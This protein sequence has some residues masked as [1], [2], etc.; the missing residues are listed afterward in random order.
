MERKF[1]LEKWRNGQI[2]FHRTKVHSRLAQFFDQFNLKEREKV[3]LPLC[4]KTLDIAWLLERE[5]HVVGVELSLIAVEQLFE[6]LRIEPEVTVQ[7]NFQV[8]RS[9]SLTIYHGDFFNLTSNEL[10]GVKGIYDRA[11]M[12]ALPMEMRRRYAAHLIEITHA[13]PQLLI[14]FHYDQGLMFGPPFAVL[15][16]EVQAHYCEAYNV[17]ALVSANLEGGLKG[18]L[19]YTSPSPRDA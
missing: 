3:F 11:S 14:T 18:C 12:V 19:L 13:A 4:G 6:E 17:K 5:V 1:W 15:E 8:Y 16:S 10:K 2:G 7:R 9:E